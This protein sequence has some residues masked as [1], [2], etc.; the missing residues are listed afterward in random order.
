VDVNI[1]NSILKLRGLQAFVATG[2]Q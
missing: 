1:L 2:M